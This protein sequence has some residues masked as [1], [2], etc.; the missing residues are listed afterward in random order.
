MDEVGTLSDFDPVLFPGIVVDLGT[1]IRAIECVRPISSRSGD[2]ILSAGRDI[3][4]VGFKSGS[5][6]ALKGAV[7]IV[8]C[9]SSL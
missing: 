2:P 5:F 7:P 3:A 9:G 8:D 4:I 6:K 1:H